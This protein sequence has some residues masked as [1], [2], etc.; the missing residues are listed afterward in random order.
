MIAK[1][2]VTV[3]STLA[4]SPDG[5]GRLDPR[6]HAYRSD[7]AAEALRGKVAAPRY[8]PGELRQ[9]VH[10]SAPLRASPDPRAP[11]TTEAL[12]GELATVYDETEGWA[13]VQLQRDGYVGYV[14]A[15]VLSAHIRQVTHE[16]RALGTFIFPAPD[17]K[18][19]PMMQ[20]SLNA[21][22]AVVEIGST[23]AKLDD[24][25]FVPS[26]H[27]TELGRFAPDFVAIAEAFL[28]VPYLWGGKT[29]LGVD[30][31]GLLQ[32]ALAAGGIACPRDSDMQASLLGAEV[33]V[34]EDLDGLKR[35][36]LVF[37]P[38][39]AGIMADAF[40]LLHAN[41]HHLAVVIEPLRT[42]AE[43]NARSGNAISTIRRLPAHSG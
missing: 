19:P 12:F 2:L 9:V 26:R 40:L 37:W 13:W 35:G 23:F 1:N 24:G 10:S 32:L 41:A 7:L 22:V 5:A 28:G 17:I 18:A 14:R 30:C 11:W 42:A 29:R 33:A 3:G 27:L 8:V 31:S 36:D 38:G 15:S 16:V 21:G 20:L 43:R 6:R 34:R 4:S 39:H 25:S